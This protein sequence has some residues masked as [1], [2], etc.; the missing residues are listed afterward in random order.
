MEIPIIPFIGFALI[1]IGFF[2]FFIKL[3]SK[4]ERIYTFKYSGLNENSFKILL[5]ILMILTF[6]IE[7]ITFSDIIIDWNQI[8]FLNYFRS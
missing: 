1:I 5:V 4:R 7:P 3:D 2:Y 8:S 6:F